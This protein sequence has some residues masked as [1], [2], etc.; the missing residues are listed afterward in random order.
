[1]MT[2]YRDQA[3]ENLFS[4]A[5]REL[6][7]EAITA[8]V[9]ASTRNRLV[10]LAAGGI[11]VTLAVLLIGWYLFSGPLLEFAVLISQFLTNPLVD[12]GEGWLALALMPVNNFA[13]ITVL[14]AKGAMMGWKKL[15]GTTLL[16]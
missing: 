3:L 6:E 16:R 13:S 7:G 9:M 8:Q 5:N 15:T 1:M 14:L 10:T 2:Q 4:E 12:L 11:T